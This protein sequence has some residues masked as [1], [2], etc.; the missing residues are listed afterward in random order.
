MWAMTV[1]ILAVV[2][3]IGPC[4]FLGVPIGIWG[5]VCHVFKTNRK[6]GRLHQ[7]H[8]YKEL[9]VASHSSE[10]GMKPRRYQ[11]VLMSLVIEDKGKLLAVSIL[12]SPARNQIQKIISTI[13]F[14]VPQTG[15][16]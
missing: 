14:Q 1:C 13:V 8:S 2:P 11:Q 6:Y 4:Y 16:E 7:K 5:P 3:L 9:Q 15:I 12:A 10:D